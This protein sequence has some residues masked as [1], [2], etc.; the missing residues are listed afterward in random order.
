MTKTQRQQK[1]NTTHA[2]EFGAKL[3]RSSTSNAGGRR[4]GYRLCEQ[5]RAAGQYFTISVTSATE[6]TARTV[7]CDRRTACRL[8][9][10]ILRGGATP[11]TLTYIIDDWEAARRDA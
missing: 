6:H 5:C 7:E 4:V 8:Y 1:Y 9:E 2:C 3:L 10:S 11:I